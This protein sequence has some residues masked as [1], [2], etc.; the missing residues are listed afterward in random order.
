MLPRF[1]MGELQPPSVE[2][3]SLHA[4]IIFAAGIDAIPNKGMMAMGH[5]DPDL[6]GPARL[7]LQRKQRHR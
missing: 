7:Q 1:G 5:M 3:L 6:M 2:G 4:Q